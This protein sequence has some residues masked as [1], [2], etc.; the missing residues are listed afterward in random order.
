ML[1]FDEMFSFQTHLTSALGTID[2]EALTARKNL[3]SLEQKAAV[4]EAAQVM[5]S[6]ESLPRNRF[7]SMHNEGREREGYILKIPSLV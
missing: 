5:T 3:A 4:L 6:G 7:N 2:E 1:T